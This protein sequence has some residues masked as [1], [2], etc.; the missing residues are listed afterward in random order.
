MKLA[1]CPLSRNVVS[2]KPASPSGAG[3]AAGTLSTRVTGRSWAKVA[4]DLLLFR[5]PRHHPPA[6]QIGRRCT[7][8]TVFPIGWGL[9]L[10]NPLRL[11]VVRVL[12]HDL[13]TVVGDDRDVL[14]P[15]AAD[16]L[17]VEAR[18]E[19]DHVAGDE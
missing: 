6:A 10:R 18:L 7:Y 3:S 2:A 9:R 15:H 11:E 17:P 1:P 19:G 13:D 8:G 5:R 14:E 12:R 16:A 4:I